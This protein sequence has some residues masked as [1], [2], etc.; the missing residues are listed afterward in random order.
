MIQLTRRGVVFTGTQADLN[1][2]RVNY[3]RDN[4]VI[5]PRLFEPVFFEEMVQRVESAPF[6]PRDHDG[7]ALELCMQDD[8]TTAVLGFFP[9]E[10]AFLR[11]VEQITGEPK[12]G[13]FVGRVYRMTA[14]DGHF[15][16]W[17]EDTIENRAVTMSVNLSRKPFR[18]G[19]LQLR[20]YASSEI[21]HEIH[22]TGFGDALLFRISPEWIHRVQGVQGEVP[23][24][25]LA[26]WFLRGQDFLSNLRNIAQ[27]ARPVV[28]GGETGADSTVVRRDE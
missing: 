25:A 18:G 23:K 6:L 14:S 13:R 5:L 15:D 8:V 22:N 24:T 9:N 21:L 26:G 11:I 19:A 16:K 27:D 1:S 10:P 7:I 4:Y 2:L 12:I 28:A 20:R 17:H 3:E